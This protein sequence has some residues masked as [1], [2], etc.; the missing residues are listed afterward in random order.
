MAGQN[1]P[2]S[3]WVFV[4]LGAALLGSPV[5]VH[6][7]ENRDTPA[8]PETALPVKVTIEM[9]QALG[10]QEAPRAEAPATAGPAVRAYLPSQPSIAALDT[11]QRYLTAADLAGLSRWEL[12]VLRNEIYARH[13][14]RFSRGDLQAYFDQQPWYRPVY[15]SNAFPEQLLN[16]TERWNAQLIA[17]FQSGGRSR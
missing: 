14:R 2:T 13:G 5:V 10:G 15:P 3:A 1:P 8:A 7:L 17:D 11:R 16:A 4:T 6:L 12:D 9:P